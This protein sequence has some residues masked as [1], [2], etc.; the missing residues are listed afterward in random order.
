MSF[1]FIALLKLKRSTGRLSRLALR[2]SVW[3]FDFFDF[4]I[5]EADYTGVFAFW[6]EQ[7]EIL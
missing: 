5:L 6:T 3:R 2:L 4:S 1:D 7:W